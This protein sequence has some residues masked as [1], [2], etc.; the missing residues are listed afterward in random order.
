M[1]WRQT[2]NPGKTSLQGDR[3]ST[4]AGMIWG[5]E[6]PRL[7]L[8]HEERERGEGAAAQVSHTGQESRDSP[9]GKGSNWPKG[10]WSKNSWESH[11]R[12]HVACGETSPGLT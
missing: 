1:R 11:P 6:N 5:K 8:E 3:Q 12:S 7:I 10:S 9:G 2:A 4:P